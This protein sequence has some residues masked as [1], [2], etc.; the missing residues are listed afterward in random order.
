M[1]RQF[2]IFLLHT[3][4]HF[5]NTVWRA[6]ISADG[7]FLATATETI[8]IFDLKNGLMVRMIDHGS[9]LEAYDESL[10][11]RIGL[12]GCIPLIQSLCF[13]LDGKSLVTGGYMGIIRIWNIYVHDN[14]RYLK[15]HTST[16]YSLD[17]FPDSR[18]LAS[19]ADYTVRIWDLNLGSLVSTVDI[20]DSNFSQIVFSTNCKLFAVMTGLQ[21]TTRIFDTETGRLVVDLLE[22]NSLAV[23]VAFSPTS[24]KVVVADDAMLRLWD[25]NSYNDE[26]KAVERHQGCAPCSF[27]FNIGDDE[28][29]VTWSRNGKW[30]ICAS[31]GRGVQVWDLQN[32]QPQFVLL[33]DSLQS[34]Y[35]VVLC[36]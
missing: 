7:N 6:C 31:D 16:V 13:T 21:G 17:V 15:G 25:L 33:Q 3:V 11:R 23:S 19:A 10:R 24:D 36:C 30:I 29:G 34:T 18:R 14:I 20:Q 26:G 1:P 35:L 8:Q 2:E 22:G 27:S 28:A 5:N 9:T 32:Q 4:E 12:G